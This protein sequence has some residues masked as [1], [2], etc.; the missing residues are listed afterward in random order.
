MNRR[1]FV[2]TGL[3][4]AAAATT[5][6]LE[7][8]NLLGR[9]SR[10]ES[11]PVGKG[12]NGDVE[13]VDE[14]VRLST[15]GSGRATGYAEANKVVTAEGRTHVTWLDSIADG[16]VVRGR[17][18]DHAAGEWSEI[19]TIGK[20]YDNHGGP[21]IT[22]DTQGY[23]HVAYYPH[24]HEM[25]YRRSSQPDTMSSWDD[26][27]EIGRNTTYP[28]LVCDGDDRLYLTC[29]VSS[30]DRWR[31][32]LFQKRRSDAS[33][34]GP[35]TVLESRS[36]GYAHFQDAMAFG[37]D[38]AVLHL[39]TR[40]HEQRP[41]DQPPRE[42]IVY[43][44]SAD[45][46]MTWTD[47]RQ[48]SVELPVT[49]NNA[50][51]IASGGRGADEPSLRCG[52]IAVAAD[53]TPY[54]LFN[55]DTV[56][57]V[58]WLADGEWNRRSL[59]EYLPNGLEEYGLHLPGGLSISTDGHWVAVATATS[60]DVVDAT[61]RW[62]HPSSEVVRFTGALG[63]S[64]EVSSRVVS[65]PDDDVP[66]W[67]PNIERTT[68]HHDVTGVPAVI[69]TAGEPGETNEDILSNGVYINRSR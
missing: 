45:G 58:S 51:V 1:L 61:D 66:H 21:T 55:E 67:L 41:N 34:D 24:H 16:F 20:A 57:Y 12:G 23:L 68:G 32:Q 31:A 38:R 44:R 59:N 26:F 30:E 2:A 14:N 17:T 63:E 11:P 39:S 62:G 54:L 27:E 36:S 35:I 7:H 28:T 6:C 53:G 33:W 3:T 22:R 4:L 19:H 47:E 49:S 69:Y 25:R 8:R 5:G 42:T 60:P 13:V 10:E 50:G 46:G 65:L 9:F 15:D 37:P 40:I 64:S 29:R 18:L 48:T 56:T 52:T 43:L